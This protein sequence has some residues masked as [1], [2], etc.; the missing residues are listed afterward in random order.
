LINLDERIKIYI[1]GHKSITISINDIIC[2]N[3]DNKH[4]FNY[5]RLW[6]KACNLQTKTHK[7]YFT[8]VSGWGVLAKWRVYRFKKR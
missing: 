4:Y 7:H 6:K 5:K 2:Y 8:N 1:I 3:R